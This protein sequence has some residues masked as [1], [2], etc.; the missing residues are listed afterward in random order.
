MITLEMIL[1]PEKFGLVQCAW[2]NGYGSSLK[3]SAATCT[4]C[5]GSGLEHACYWCDQPKSQHVGFP[6]KNNGNL[7]CTSDFNDD[8]TFKPKTQSTPPAGPDGMNARDRRRL[9]RQSQRKEK[10]G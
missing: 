9:R 4:V 7:A 10:N 1:N 3:E 2:C 8:R 6:A 5:G